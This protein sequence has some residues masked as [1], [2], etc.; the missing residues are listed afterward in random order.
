MTQLSLKFKTITNENKND[1]TIQSGGSQ[2][3]LDGSMKVMN[4]S[5]FGDAISAFL[6]ERPLEIDIKL[7]VPVSAFVFPVCDVVTCCVAYY[8]MVCCFHVNVDIILF[9]VVCRFTSS[10]SSPPRS[11]TP[12]KPWAPWVTT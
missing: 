7:K 1:Y 3:G 2:T 9:S 5:A 4:E 6:S 12:A 11:L 8:A 10:T